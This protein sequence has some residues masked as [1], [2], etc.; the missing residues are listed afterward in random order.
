MI[1]A[2]FCMGQDLTRKGLMLAGSSHGT[3]HVHPSWSAKMKNVCWAIS[4]L[5]KRVQK[6]ERVVVLP[7]RCIMLIGLEIGYRG[8]LVLDLGDETFPQIPVFCRVFHNGEIGIS[9]GMYVKSNG[10]WEW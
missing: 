6:L 7:K 5:K 8:V 10:I 3:N 1:N 9:G 2:A 4:V